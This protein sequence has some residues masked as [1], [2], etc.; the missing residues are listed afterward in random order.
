MCGFISYAGKY[1]GNTPHR[2]Q[3]F[4]VLDGGFIR[5][6]CTVPKEVEVSEN[7]TSKHQRAEAS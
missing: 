2:V 1:M 5:V 7:S 4:S 6:G 3:L